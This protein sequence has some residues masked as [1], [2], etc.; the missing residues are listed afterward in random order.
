M[1]V[2]STAVRGDRLVAVDT[3]EEVTAIRGGCRAMAMPGAVAEPSLGFPHFAYALLSVSR[4]IP[5]DRHALPLAVLHHRVAPIVVRGS[6]KISRNPRGVLST[7]MNS[8]SP[9]R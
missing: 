1:G 8:A 4:L 7:V 5:D 6:S 2:T 3:Q 9:S